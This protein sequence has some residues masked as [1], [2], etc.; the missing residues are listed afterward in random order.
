MVLVVLVEPWEI[1]LI[2]R[3]C[4]TLMTLDYGNYGIFLLHPNP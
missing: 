1:L 4:I 3:S 2:Y